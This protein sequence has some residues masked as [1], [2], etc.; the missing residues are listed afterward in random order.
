[1]SG[2]ASE[3][4]KYSDGGRTR[5][6]HRVEGSNRRATS[7]VFAGRFRGC[8]REFRPMTAITGGINP[9]CHLRAPEDF[10]IMS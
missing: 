7:T 6:K 8:V 2:G 10:I 3:L 1:M 5:E 9:L 4:C